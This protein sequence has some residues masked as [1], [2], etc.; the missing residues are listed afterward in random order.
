[1][2]LL[3]NALTSANESSMVNCLDDVQKI[4]ANVDDA[5]NSFI[6][7]SN[8]EKGA[9]YGAIRARLSNYSSLMKTVI[10]TSKYLKEDVIGANSA[11][12]AFM[13]EYSMLNDAQIDEIENDIR[14]LER[15]RDECY[16]RIEAAQYDISIDV[17][18]ILS[19]LNFIN[20]KLP[21]LKKKLDKLKLLQPTDS[22]NYN[23]INTNFSDIT[24]STS[25]AYAVS[26]AGLGFTTCGNNLFFF[27]QLGW[28]DKDGNVLEDKTGIYT[29]HINQWNYIN[30]K[31]N[32]SFDIKSS[33][34]NIT[35]FASILSSLTGQIYTPTEISSLLNVDEKNQ[36]NTPKT[37]YMTDKSQQ[38]WKWTESL[39]IN[40]PE[41]GVNC[42]YGD[43]KG[44]AYNLRQGG[45]AMVCVNGGKHWVAVLGI[46]DKG[47]CIVCDPNQKNPYSTST[48]KIDESGKITDGN[49]TY[50]GSEIVYF[51]KK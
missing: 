11:M 51:N 45:A 7:N 39:L 41:L 21:E 15:D 46:D 26:S 43:S 38:G 12:V 8:K 18:S 31:K 22:I 17:S 4:F 30:D 50:D 32:W 16:K 29:A 44:L 3:Q 20:E 40:H 2:L 5:I 14:C 28:V 1:M 24:Q 23:S 34:C 42:E 47:N 25:G 48:W 19:Y 9:A 37:I 33:G 49:Q 36:K 10:N 27:S 35:S 13:E 6:T